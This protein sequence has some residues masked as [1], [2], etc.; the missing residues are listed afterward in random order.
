M[1]NLV[2]ILKVRQPIRL[3]PYFCDCHELLPKRLIEYLNRKQYNLEKI[4]G[5]IDI[6]LTIYEINW[7]I[8]DNVREILY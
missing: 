6:E 1:N 7:N 5:S 4:I 8:L 3:T 2:A